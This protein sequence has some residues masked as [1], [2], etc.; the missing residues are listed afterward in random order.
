MTWLAPI[1]L[2]LVPTE[3]TE[4]YRHFP[5]GTTGLP[6]P[7]HPGA[8]GVTRKHHVHEGVDLYAPVGTAVFAVEAGTVTA[9][10]P[11]TG[12]NAGLPWWLDTEAIFV[13]G[14][15]GAVLYGELHPAVR[16]GQHVV[17]G[18]FLGTVARVLRHEKGRP[19]SM[20]HLE[21]H[22]PGTIDAPEWHLSSAKPSSLI[23]PT[24]FLLQARGSAQPLTRLND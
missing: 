21:L 8:F 5:L 13:E 6:L 17:A 10:K 3:D 9:V 14:P 15:S 24:P 4:S 18:Q 16:L 1:P 11:F 12:P 20:L 23:D 2:V 19:T 22:K 7:P